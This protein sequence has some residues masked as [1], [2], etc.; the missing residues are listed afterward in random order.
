MGARC[1]GSDWS[2]TGVRDD[3]TFMIRSWH[4]SSVVLYIGFDWQLYW[5][6]IIG[7]LIVWELLTSVLGV[8]NSFDSQWM[9]GLWLGPVTRCARSDASICDW[10]MANF[11]WL[12]V[13]RNFIYF[14]EVYVSSWTDGGM[15]ASLTGSPQCLFMLAGVFVSGVVCCYYPFAGVRWAV[16]VYN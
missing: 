3:W 5:W 2:V 7:T 9:V 12:L 6:S 1:V 13:F 16:R 11:I 15:Y 14:G 4:H 10:L 8:K